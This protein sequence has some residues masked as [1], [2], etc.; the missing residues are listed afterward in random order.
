ML[1]LWP[2]LFLGRAAI[3]APRVTNEK[4]SGY[5]GI[6]FDHAVS[7]QYTEALRQSGLTKAELV[8]WSRALEPL[9]TIKGR[10]LWVGAELHHIA[11]HNRPMFETH[12]IHDV[13]CVD[14]TRRDIFPIPQGFWTPLLARCRDFSALGE[15]NFTLDTDNTSPFDGFQSTF[16]DTLFIE[17]H[18]EAL[19][20]INNR[21]YNSSLIATK[22]RLKAMQAY[23]LD[24]TPTSDDSHTAALYRYVSDLL[25]QTTIM[26]YCHESGFNSVKTNPQ[27][28]SPHL[29]YAILG[30]GTGKRGYSSVR[31][32]HVARM[33]PDLVASFRLGAN[34]ASQLSSVE[35]DDKKRACHV[36][37]WEHASRLLPEITFQERTMPLKE[38]L[39]S[40]R[41][42]SEGEGEGEGEGGEGEGGEGG[43]ASPERVAAAMLE[44]VYWLPG[45]QGIYAKRPFGARTRGF[46]DGREDSLQ[47]PSIGAGRPAMFSP[48]ERLP[49][50]DYYYHLLNR[51]LRAAL[52]PLSRARSR[53][54][55]AQP[56]SVELMPTL[57]QDHVK[58][59]LTSIFSSHHIRVPHSDSVCRYVLKEIERYL[60]SAADTRGYYTYSPQ[61]P[62]WD[63]AYRQV[64][65]HRAD[66]IEAAMLANPYH[67]KA[68]VARLTHRTPIGE[69]NFTLSTKEIELVS[70]PLLFL[71]AAPKYIQQIKPKRQR[72]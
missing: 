15:R 7:S 23:L 56:W 13:L 50:P 26:S 28:K 33:C 24:N 16:S 72:M 40:A 35:L 2:T 42:F 6:S 61:V 41:R 3:P 45:M 62:P 38:F 47:V 9:H 19:A 54:T 18:A 34:D 55:Y 17:E 67:G 69:R 58:H 44:N 11:A 51:K 22:A 25:L 4:S 48:M 65:T 20:I 29:F 64:M 27:G 52:T 39:A 32:S 63:E 1:V 49:S 31:G 66:R 70:S 14:G 10:P 5:E 43:D 60:V 21:R 8:P 71:S 46:T 57:L 37:Q 12:K 68:Q 59:I 36:V 30:E 53:I